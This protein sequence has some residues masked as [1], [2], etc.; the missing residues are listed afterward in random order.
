MNGAGS[1]DGD[2]SAA[3]SEMT[4]EPTGE[5]APSSVAPV[6]RRNTLEASALVPGATRSAS[7]G[8]ERSA[9]KIKVPARRQTK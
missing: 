3:T 9:T 2:E 8:H 1:L 5:S 6:A 4:H 7:E